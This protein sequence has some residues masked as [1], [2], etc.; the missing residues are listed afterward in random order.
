MQSASDLS[1]LHALLTNF[2]NFFLYC[3]SCDF[4]FTLTYNQYKINLVVTMTCIRR[5]FTV[6]DTLNLPYSG[7]SETA[8]SIFV[9][10]LYI[11]LLQTY[12]DSLPRDNSDSDSVVSSVVS[13][14]RSSSTVNS[15]YNNDNLATVVQCR[16]ASSENGVSSAQEMSQA[17]STEKPNYVPASILKL[18]KNKSKEQ[19]ELNKKKVSFHQS[20]RIKS[21]G[22]ALRSPTH[23]LHAPMFTFS[24]AFSSTNSKLYTVD[25]V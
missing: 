2:K 15:S 8:V 23:S 4:Q 1:P 11:Q 13:Q 9:H 6:T 3:H 14:S 10:S 16:K 5:Q 25:F 12:E 19:A 24:Q 21:R 7:D 22:K 18:S 20:V 17:D